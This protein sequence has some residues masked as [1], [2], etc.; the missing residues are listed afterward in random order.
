[1]TIRVSSCIL[2]GIIII[3]GIVLFQIKYTVVDFENTHQRLKRAICIKNEEIHVLNA[4][5]AYLNGSTRLQDLADKYLPRLTPIKGEQMVS[6]VQF[7]NSGLGETCSSD[8]YDRKALDQLVESMS[9][10][11]KSS[12][13]TEIIKKQ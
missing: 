10:N 13:K 8:E 9:R 7:Q 3:L 4:E 6:Y 2:G 12:K 11:S 1:M 5:W